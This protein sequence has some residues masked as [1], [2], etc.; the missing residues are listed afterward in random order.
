MA[1]YSSSFLPSRDAVGM[2]VDFTVAT[3]HVARKAG[4]DEQGRG[5]SGDEERRAQGERRR[6]NASPRTP[7]TSEGEEVSDW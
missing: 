4:E 1:G 6:S 5:R 3:C 2:L 7:R